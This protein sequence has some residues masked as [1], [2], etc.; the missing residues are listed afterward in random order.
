MIH[1]MFAIIDYFVLLSHPKTEKVFFFFYLVTK[2][3]YHANPNSWSA[4]LFEAEV[5]IFSNFYKEAH[6]V[7]SSFA[8]FTH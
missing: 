4:Q 6:S 2:P 3:L 5:A 8:Y 1:E 7:G